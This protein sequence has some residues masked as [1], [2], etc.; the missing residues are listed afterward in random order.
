VFAERIHDIEYHSIAGGSQYGIDR[1]ERMQSPLAID[2]SRT[3]IIIESGSNYGRET[4]PR[5]HYYH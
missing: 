2:D 4:R 5:R 1:V 3:E